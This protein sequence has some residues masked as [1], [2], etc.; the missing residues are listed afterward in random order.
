MNC[1]IA[2]NHFVG[3][4]HKMLRYNNK[5]SSKVI[6]IILMI[7]N[8]S[9]R[10]KYCQ[11]GLNFICFFFQ[12]FCIKI[13]QILPHLCLDQLHSNLYHNLHMKIIVF[14]SEIL[15]LKKGTVCKSLVRIYQIIK[16]V[17]S[18]LVARSCFLTRHSSQELLSG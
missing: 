18:N 9:K 14:F 8:F 17:S 16:L 6:I 11:I 4:A 15:P 10:K 12:N 1:L 3:L 13:Q 2:F 5:T 7:N